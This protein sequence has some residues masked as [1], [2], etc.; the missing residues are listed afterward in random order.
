MQLFILKSKSWY[1]LNLL[2]INH[3]KTPVGKQ[4]QTQPFKIE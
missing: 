2:A 3:L 4:M 1:I